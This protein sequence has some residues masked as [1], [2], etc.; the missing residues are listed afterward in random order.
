MGGCL[1]PPGLVRGAGL[2]LRAAAA[3]GRSAELPPTLPARK[4]ANAD[5]KPSLRRPAALCLAWSTGHSLSGLARPHKAPEAG[6]CA[7]KPG[8]PG[9]SPPTAPRGLPRPWTRSRRWF[10]RIWRGWHCIREAP[11]PAASPTGARQAALAPIAGPAEPRATRPRSRGWRWLGAPAAPRRPAATSMGHRGS[12]QPGTAKQ[13]EPL[14]SA[15]ACRTRTGKTGLRTRPPGQ[16]V[17]SQRRPGATTAPA[18][19]ARTFRQASLP[20]TRTTAPLRGTTHA[21]VR[22]PAL[23]CVRQGRSLPHPPAGMPWHA[24]KQGG[25]GPRA[26]DPARPPRPAASPRTGI[27]GGQCSPPAV[28]WAPMPSP[29]T[30]VP[31]RPPSRLRQVPVAG[32]RTPRSSSFAAPWPPLQ[33][34]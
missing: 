19:P 4:T 20:A 6:T 27:S 28:L 33:T 11:R 21:R 24:S 30:L 34:L 3:A 13:S 1:P 31:A 16:L 22:F 29:F 2:G 17:P 9:A 15:A 18:G 12:P 10:A 5:G 25:I 8:P 23:G 32:Q 7:P 26:S 14:R